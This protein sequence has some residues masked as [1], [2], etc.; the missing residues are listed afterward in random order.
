[1][2]ICGFVS[3]RL[4]LFVCSCEAPVLLCI[5][6]GDFIHGVVSLS[7]GPSTDWERFLPLVRT[8]GARDVHFQTPRWSTKHTT[9]STLLE[10]GNGQFG[11]SCSFAR[12][13][14]HVSFGGT[15]GSCSL[16]LSGST[17]CR[18]TRFEKGVICV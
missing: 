3:H 18:R 2:W 14:S 13:L 11:R 8:D 5:L 6:L 4:G 12:E 15:K 17:R 9:C 16:S 10:T 7:R 1:M